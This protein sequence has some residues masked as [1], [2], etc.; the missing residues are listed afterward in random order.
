MAAQQASP[1]VILEYVRQLAQEL[2]LKDWEFSF[3]ESPAGDDVYATV[4]VA[5]GSQAR[6]RL[7]N[8]FWVELDP[9]GQR[10]TLVHELCHCHLWLMEVT[11]L[12]KE[13]DAPRTVITA[14]SSVLRLGEEHAVN[15]FARLLS[16]SLPLPPWSPQRRTPDAQEAEIRQPARARRTPKKPKK[17]KGRARG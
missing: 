17:G 12:L 16:P 14:V 10:E 3:D 5:E 11:E 6:L 2:G 4:A 8:E 13:L 1:Q 9:S 15:I 7:S